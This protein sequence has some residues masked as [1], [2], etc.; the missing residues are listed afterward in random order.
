M[1]ECPIPMRLCCEGCGELHIDEGEFERARMRLL[2][3]APDRIDGL[4]RGLT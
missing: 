3:L 4:M 2:E 1:P